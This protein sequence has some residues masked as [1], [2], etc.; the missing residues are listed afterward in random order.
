V[1]ARIAGMRG[2]KTPEIGTFRAIFGLR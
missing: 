1:G 2:P